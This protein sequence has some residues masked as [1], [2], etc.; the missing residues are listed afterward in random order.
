MVRFP[1]SVGCGWGREKTGIY[2]LFY[3]YNEKVDEYGRR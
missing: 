1:S 2:H 3:R